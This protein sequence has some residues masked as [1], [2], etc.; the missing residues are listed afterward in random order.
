LRKELQGHLKDEI[1]RLS[2]LLDRDL[3]HW[4]RDDEQRR[5]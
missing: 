1:E 4:L 3:T 2:D 5:A